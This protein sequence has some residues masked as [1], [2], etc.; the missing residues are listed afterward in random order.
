MTLGKFKFLKLMVKN[1][2]DVGIIK[3]R[4]LVEYKIQNY[5]KDVPIF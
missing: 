1:A 3:K 2:I 5:A 4:Q